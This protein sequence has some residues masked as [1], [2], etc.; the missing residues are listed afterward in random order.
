VL[1]H[2]AKSKIEEAMISIGRWKLVESISLLI[3][4]GNTATLSV[5]PG[6][7][8]LNLRIR[9]EGEST[10]RDQLGVDIKSA[11]DGFGEITFNNWTNV[12]GTAMN[13]PASL[14][15]SRAGEPILFL[16]AHWRIG[17]LD[18]IDLQILTE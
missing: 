11:P 15:R 12:L 1:D 18:K 5:A 3:P 9:F 2:P 17:L 16:A 4:R 8:R 7:G 14:G 13:E 6:L 10:D